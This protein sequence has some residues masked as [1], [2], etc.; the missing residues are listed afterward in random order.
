MRI[1]MAKQATSIFIGDSKISV[2]QAIGKQPQNWAILPLAPGL[3][4]DGVI[5]DVNAVATGV[6]EVCQK[7][8][9][10]GGKVIAGISGINCLYRIISLPSIPENMLPEAVKREAARVLGVPMEQFYLSWQTLPTTSKSE[11]RIYLVAT[12]K[13]TVDTL[14]STLRKAGLNPYLMDLKPLALA[15][16]ITESEAIILDVQ[17]T[18]FDIVIMTD[19]TPQVVRSLPIAPD[20]SQEERLSLIKDELERAITFYNSSH[21]E[22]SLD[23]MAPLLVS[24][25][26]AGQ[27]DR[28]EVLSGVQGNTVRLLPC[29]LKATNEFPCSQYTTNIGLTFKVTA[30]K[31]AT[32]FSLV[33]LNVFPEIYRPKPRPV[34]EV[35]FIPVLIGGV[36]L[37]VL[38]AFTLANTIAQKD[39]TF[40]DYPAILSSFIFT[41]NTPYTNQLQL[42]LDNITQTILLKTTEAKTEIED[43]EAEIKALTKQFSTQVQEQEAVIEAFNSVLDPLGPGRD[44]ING[45]LG[46]MNRLPGALDLLSVKHDTETMTIQGIADDENIILGYA[47][48]LRGS[49]RFALVVVSSVA[50]E[51][52]NSRTRFTLTLTKAKEDTE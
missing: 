33:N 25:D 7:A 46:E 41:H 29:P 6:R 19:I 5:L 15:R 2:L 14:I 27:E 43:Y 52:D 23:P 20:A 17:P 8:H 36:A 31:A 24:G 11:I 16:T 9:I 45:D 51:E 18:S 4:K 13:K 32:A 44:E 22:H 39:T 1:K 48:A 40:S 37:V 42:E 21:K 26:L 50:Y 10:G 49:G 34:H 35:L 28:W 47:S 12:P 30:E 38:G 3:V